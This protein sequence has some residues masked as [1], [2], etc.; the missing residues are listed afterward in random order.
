MIYDFLY[1]LDEKH[2]SKSIFQVWK[3]NWLQSRVVPLESYPRCTAR[4]PRVAFLVD[5]QRA[6]L[7][8]SVCTR[9]CSVW[10]VEINCVARI[11]NLNVFRVY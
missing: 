6:V 8:S 1:E 4:Q 10:E 2:D 9:G 3:G 11:I 7:L 5:M